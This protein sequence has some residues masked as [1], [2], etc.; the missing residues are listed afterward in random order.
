MGEDSQPNYNLNG[1]RVKYAG[2]VSRLGIK[3]T[4][5]SLWFLINDKI[6]LDWDFWDEHTSQV[7]GGGV[8]VTD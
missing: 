5:L 1:Y 4:Q 7:R 2:G 6:N 3:W 8:W